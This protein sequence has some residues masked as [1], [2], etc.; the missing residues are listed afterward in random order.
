MTTSIEAPGPFAAFVAA[1][2]RR[3]ELVVQPR[4]GFSDPADM[5]RGLLATRAARATS[6]GTITLDSY[7]R[8]RDYA[9]ARTALADGTRLNGYPIVNHPAAVTRGVLGGLAGPDFPVQVRHGSAQPCEIIEAL[10]ALGLDATEGGPISY[11]LPYGRVPVRD[12][13][14]EWSRACRLFL[15]LRDTFGTEPHLESF[16]G[17]MLGQ[18]CPPSL[19]IAISVLE[20]VFFR[21]H[22]LR[23]VSL[24]YAQQTSRSQDLEALAALRVLAAEYL[25]DLDW[26]IVLYT[27]MGV[28]PTS[29][30]GALR[31]LCDS[32]E[33]AVRG[34]AARLIVKT[35][36]EATRVPTVAENIEALEL[37]GAVAAAS[38]RL[39][40]GPAEPATESGVLAEATALIEAV[41]NLHGDVGQALALGVER[42]FLDVP[43]CLHPDNPGRTRS[44]IEPDGRLAW[45]DTGH[46]PLGAAARRSRSA[47][48]G[49]MELLSALSCM[50]DRYDGDADR[51][52]L[53]GGTT[54]LPG[55]RRTDG[56][57]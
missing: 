35:S 27:Y 28:Y 25:G 49:S 44:R 7:T 11:C 50:R 13:I 34:D 36:A 47:R 15:R 17:C 30:D 40:L 45:S 48:L 5:R 39:L 54:A 12:S 2:H 32:A 16:G 56:A 21:A 29:R 22:G 57:R 37:A 18:L 41:L 14:R 4:M 33:L 3:G 51:W 1:A 52:S 23:S 55:G 24:S 9:S 42:G 26:H 43:Y 46:L 31:L 20:C 6:V 10:T 38:Q 19:L 8:V 53:V